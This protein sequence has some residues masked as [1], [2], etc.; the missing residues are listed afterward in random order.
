M[1]KNLLR[2]ILHLD[3]DAFF[4][5]VEE[6]EDPSLRGKPF[7][8]GG[9]PQ[10]RGVVASCSYAA[11]AFGIHSALPMGRALQLCPDLI[12]IQHGHG[13]YSQ[14]SHQVMERLR[15]LSALVEQISIDEAFVDLS[16]LREATR[17]TVL[18]LQNQ[19]WEELRLPC[20]VGVASNKLLAKIANETGKKAA[21]GPDYPRAVTVVEAGHEAEFLAP[22]PAAM[23]WGVGPK[24]ESR[25]ASLG[26]HTI[27]DI[28]RF[29]ESE[30]AAR[31]G[32][33]GRDLSRHA[34][35]I[36]ERPVVPERETK[37]ISQETTFIRDLSDDKLLETT[38]KN[39]AEEVAHNLRREHLAGKTVKLKLRWPDFST[40]TRQTTLPAAS[41]QPHE[42]YEAALSLLRQVRT[43]GQAV[44]L[45]GVG[46]SGLGQPVHQMGLWGQSNEKQRKLQSVVDELQEKYGKKVIDKGLR[47]E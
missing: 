8:V 5:A 2:T 34:R 20:S 7:A 41:D 21:R 3:L 26:L 39:L 25:L 6:L 37:S 23:L 12:I 4:C 11:R 35:G 38:L 40:L 46:V 13:K 15:N 36:D 32:Q 16:D 45:I 43:P 17:P 33:S 31:F 10:E 9:R 18:R 44:R 24:T 27:G 42:I 1:Q 28:A 22:L 47:D 19:I 14:K 29:P 30:L